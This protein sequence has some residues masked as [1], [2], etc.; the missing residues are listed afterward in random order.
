MM[1]LYKP[2]YYI[3]RAQHPRHVLSQD[4]AGK[5]KVCNECR[6]GWASLGQPWRGTVALSW[7]R[8]GGFY[9]RP[10]RICVGF[11]ALT[12][13][14]GVELDDLMRAYADDV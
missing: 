7:G 13:V 5:V 1:Y 3:H 10:T 12:I 8:W 9:L 4:Y 14:P 11:F 2:D 6:M